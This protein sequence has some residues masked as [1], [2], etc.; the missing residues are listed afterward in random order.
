M[1]K[2]DKALRPPS[3]RAKLAQIRGV[4]GDEKAL[5]QRVG[6]LIDVLTF[7]QRQNQNPRG[8]RRRNSSAVPVPQN[9][10]VNT[11]TGGIQI[12]WDPV[13]AN[14][15]DFYEVQI[16]ES[17]TFASP[18]EFQV[19]ES[20]I[21]YRAQPASGI[22]FFRLRTVTK[23][24]EVSN[25]TATEQ[26]TISAAN[27]FQVDE[28]FIDPENRTTVSPKPTLIGAN[29]DVGFGN[30]AFTGIGAYIG[31]SPLTL[32]DNFEGFRASILRRNEVS[33]TLFQEGSPYPGLEQRFAPTIGEYIDADGF[34]VY[35]PSFYT[36]MACLPGSI[37]DFFF[38][39]LLDPA[40]SPV[41][42][43]V[44]FLRYVPS[45]SFYSPNFAQTGIVFN[46]SMS[47]IKF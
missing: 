10:Q 6:N 7:A 5:L 26:I 15:L 27:V 1:P 4:S 39:E 20:N 42:L 33:Y 34:Y 40:D 32:D 35:T 29:F 38:E 13:D 16:D 25:W 44:E 22:L 19:V 31:P 21:S 8:Q 46:A 11:V 30:V 36:G 47:N 14:E 12:F 43:K 17:T 41:Q 18:D 3:Y 2:D 9:V 45:T 23:R 24:G 28:D 37:S